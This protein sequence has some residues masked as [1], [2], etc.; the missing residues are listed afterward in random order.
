MKGR[1]P[2]ALCNMSLLAPSR[3]PQLIPATLI[4]FPKFTTDCI[5]S[6]YCLYHVYLA[7]I[8]QLYLSNKQLYPII[9]VIVYY[10]DTGNAFQV[11]QSHKQYHHSKSINIIHHKIC[12][13]FWLI[14]WRPNATIVP[15]V[16]D[17]IFLRAWVEV[18]KTGTHWYNTVCTVLVRPPL[19]LG[20]RLFEWQISLSQCLWFW[21]EEECTLKC[22]RHY[23]SPFLVVPGFKLFLDGGTKSGNIFLKAFSEHLNLFPTNWFF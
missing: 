6:T 21:P 19:S 3:I 2:L 7:F 13:W 1:S 8:L 5:C 12:A 15:T 9:I 23:I 17:G 16:T 18:G 20:K 10:P 14:I 22:R 11:F 4:I